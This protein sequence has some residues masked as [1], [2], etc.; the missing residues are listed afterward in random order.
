LFG[1][2]FSTGSLKGLENRVQGT[3]ALKHAVAV[4]IAIDGIDLHSVLF[5]VI[6]A[7][8]GPVAVVSVVGF[9]SGAGGGI[10][11]VR[12]NLPGVDIHGWNSWGRG[13][14]D[15][16]VLN[17]GI[18]DRNGGRN[19]RG[20]RNDE[21]IARP[22][23]EPTAPGLD[24]GDVV[25]EDAIAPGSPVRADCSGSALRNESSAGHPGCLGCRGTLAVTKIRELYGAHGTYRASEATLTEGGT[26]KGGR[27]NRGRNGSR[28]RGRNR[29]RNRNGNVVE[30]ESVD[31]GGETVIAV[32]SRSGT[33]ETI[34]VDV[35]RVRIA[36]WDGAKG[37]NDRSVEGNVLSA[38]HC[39][40]GDVRAR[41]CA[42]IHQATP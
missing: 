5:D 35:A 41:A 6:L 32:A 40:R 19:G 42:R 28:N 25:P 16:F 37:A 11:E 13:G 27:R 24:G 33:G 21:G 2:S 1:V 12:Q 18:D 39:V 4:A 10:D 38:F 17:N 15:G 23:D 20:D 34:V 22:L 3:A 9:E 7:A 36:W 30:I 29:G 31:F 26:S 8:I 14:S